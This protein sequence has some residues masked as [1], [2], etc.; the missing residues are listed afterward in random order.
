MD[1]VE[2]LCAEFEHQLPLYVGRDLEPELLVA[3]ERHAAA[4][5]LCATRA[6]AAVASRSVLVRGLAR[7]S[8]GPAVDLWSDVRGRLREEGVLAPPLHFAHA[9]RFARLAGFGTAAAAMLMVGFWL[10]SREP[11]ADLGPHSAP[12]IARPT[13]SQPSKTAI[14]ANA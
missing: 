14:F 13:S 8:R 6:R 9:R 4:C 10:G 3:L 12:T 2:N 5:A 1:H 7:A 11:A